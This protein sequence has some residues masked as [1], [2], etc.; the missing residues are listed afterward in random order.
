M[1]L[2]IRDKMKRSIFII[3]LAFV[4]HS[5]AENFKQGSGTRYQTFNTTPQ[6]IDLYWRDSNGTQ[7]RDF[8]TLQTALMRERKIIRFMMN[9][10][11]FEPGGI[12]SGL[13]VINGNTEHEINT[14]DGEGNFYLQPNGV[15]WIDSAGAHITS[16]KEYV[17][18]KPSPRIAIQSGP[19]LVRNS[20]I[21]PVFNSE[22]GNHLHRN[23]VG[24]R[25]DGSVLFAMTVFDQAR[26]PNLHEFATQFIEQGCTDALF[27]DGDLSG[28]VT[29]VKERLNPGNCYGAIFAVT[30]ETNEAQQAV[31]GYPPQSVGSPDP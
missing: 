21:N 4:T 15:F 31:P 29:N 3:I 5:I 1:T 19:L 22:S 13:L 27:L 18:R 14:R 6:N 8:A 11:I 12:P 20:R 26:H 10:G 28:M 7:Y 23:G 9:A 17:A 24:I 2:G 16:T 25:K 30:E